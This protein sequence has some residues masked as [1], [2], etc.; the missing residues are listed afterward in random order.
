MVNVY[1]VFDIC[2][3][4]C[5][6]E[7]NVLCLWLDEKIFFIIFLLYLKLIIFFI[8]IWLFNDF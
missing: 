7:R 2:L 1:K 6:C 4:C 5:N 3:L 8:L